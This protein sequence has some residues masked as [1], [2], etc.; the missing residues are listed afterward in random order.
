MS[1]PHIAVAFTG[2]PRTA[3]LPDVVDYLNRAL[4][5]VQN[6]L[7]PV[8][9]TLQLNT[10]TPRVLGSTVW[11]TNS[12]SATSITAFL[13]GIAEQ[14]IVIVATDAN[15]ILVT[16]T[17]LVT[18]SGANIVLASGDTRT[19]VCVDGIVWRET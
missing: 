16:G 8:V 10:A 15:T 12:T 17:T 18:K 7:S 2:C 9:G 11:K 13:G 1:T 19:F 6:A 5:L 3:A 4:A 14:E